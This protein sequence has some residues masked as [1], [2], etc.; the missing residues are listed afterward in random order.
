MDENIINYKNITVSI[1]KTHIKRLGFWRA[2]IGSILMY[3][4][5]PFFLFIHITLTLI[6]YKLFLQPLFNLPYIK[7]KNYIILDRFNVPGLGLIDRVNCLFCDYANGVIMLFHAEIDQIAVGEKR[8]A[9][10]KIIL[11]FI[12]IIPITLFFSLGIFISFI[13]TKGIV[14]LFG[15][16]RASV[17]RIKQEIIKDQYASQYKGFSQ[18]LIRFYKINAKVIS[19]NL[20]QIESAWCPIKHLE[21]EGRVFPVQH[22]NFFNRIEL[23]SMNKTLEEKGTTSDKLPK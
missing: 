7:P 3:F 14:S 13:L 21:R 16:H 9:F 5:F 1:F 12:Y 2:L 11:I 17:R 15:F 10:F 8:L 23:E 22:K 18:K 6:C 20:E 4:T 19:Y